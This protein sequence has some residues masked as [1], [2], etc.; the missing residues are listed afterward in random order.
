LLPQPLHLPLQRTT[1][2]QNISC[3]AIHWEGLRGERWSAGSCVKWCKWN[4]TAAKPPFDERSM[5]RHMHHDCAV[6][7]PAREGW[8]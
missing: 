2:A 4:A 3:N 1:C 8:G 7:A 6:K 5:W